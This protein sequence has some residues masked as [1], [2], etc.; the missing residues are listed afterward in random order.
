MRTCSQKSTG[1]HSGPTEV[2]PHTR[3]VCL[4]HLLYFR[5]MSGT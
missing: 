2:R 3:A 4:R 1:E 5:V